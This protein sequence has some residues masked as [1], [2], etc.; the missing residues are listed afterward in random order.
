MLKSL[1]STSSLN[2]IN[3]TLVSFGLLSTNIAK[4]EETVSID[5]YA[6]GNTNANDSYGPSFEIS[7]RN[8]KKR[9]LVELDYMQP[10]VGDDLNLTIV[11]LK[12]KADNKK[13][14]EVNLGGIYR[15]NF[16]DNFI[17]GVYGYYDYRKTSFG[18]SVSGFTPGVKVLSKYID[19]RANYYLPQARKK[20]IK[21][22]GIS[23]YAVSGGHTYEY[24]L[25]GYD[26]E[27]GTSVFA[28]SDDLNE[29]LGTKI[30]AAHYDFSSKHTKHVTGNRFR[31]EQT[32]GR[33]QLGDNSLQFKL[34]GE[35]QYDKARKR[36]NFI[37]I[38]AKFT[39]DDRTKKTGLKARMMDTVIRDVDI[40][41]QSQ[42]SPE[43]IS[44]FMLNGH[45]INKIYYIGAADANYVGDG[46]QAKPFSIE[47]FEKIN[48]NDCLIIFVP[49]NKTEGGRD[50]TSQEFNRFRN[51]PQVV[52]GRGNLFLTSNSP[53]QVKLVVQANNGV[54]ISGQEGAVIE[55]DIKL[56]GS[57]EKNAVVT[58][59]PI[60]T[61]SIILV[62]EPVTHQEVIYNNLDRE[63]QQQEQIREQAAEQARV[64][65]AEEAER[66]R[67][68]QAARTEAQNQQRVEAQR[69]AGI[70]RAEA[71]ERRRQEQ[72]TEAERQQ[73]QQNNDGDDQA[74]QNEANNAQGRVQSQPYVVERLQLTQ[75]EITARQNAATP[76]DAANIFDSAVNPA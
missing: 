71:A 15:H 31:F 67:L 13:S 4:G 27:I 5:Q 48:S 45:K 55:S 76:A 61:S 25:R 59:A 56:P 42:K 74:E 63:N 65:T 3:I 49:I 37:G 64:A 47:Q 11:D 24:A 41:T 43:Q 51:K 6:T 58:S 60:E 8:S 29:K 16:D 1:L 10:V 32:I 57:S 53:D 62:A 73:E 44:S 46:T 30:F 54:I 26:F 72:Q 34:N 35:T 20:K 75:A 68:T 66:Q 40:M 12:L 18:L 23:I 52:N 7:S 69:Q 2:L 36:Q 50:A 17:F 33:L 39:F 28:F 22:Q 14:K 21:I 19:L 9:N 70:N 38:G